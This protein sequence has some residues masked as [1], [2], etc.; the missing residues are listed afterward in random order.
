MA[1]QPHR[2]RLIGALLAI[3]VLLVPPMVQGRQTTAGDNVHVYLPSVP[4][5]TLSQLEQQVVDLTNAMRAQ[6]GCVPLTISA[7]LTHA[8]RS[9]SADMASRNYFSHTSPSPGS[10]NPIERAVLSGYIPYS[11][12]AENIA[13]G[14]QT[15]AD[16]VGG[17]YRST[18]HRQNMLDCN[19]K[20]IGV[21]YGY[22]PNS[23]FRHYWT[24]AFGTRP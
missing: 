22:G 18:R 16:V 8:A 17:W 3:V 15:A 2:V 20:E 12:I 13:A 1:I 21:G 11:A 23:D 5:Y 19:L 4:N 6:Q 9:H 10:T 24:Q 14:Y 7:E